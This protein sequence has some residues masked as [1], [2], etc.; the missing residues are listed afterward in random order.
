MTAE[1]EEKDTATY[2]PDLCYRCDG[3]MGLFSLKDTW[4][5]NVDGTLHNVP[6]FS[7]PCLKCLNCGVTLLN[8]WSDEI[9]L[10]CL[11]KYLDQRGLNTRWH[12]VRRAIRRRIQRYCDRWN[13]YMLRFDKWRGK[14]A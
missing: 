5:M 12:K 6:V 3:Q 13:W 4:K 10:Y 9:V 7:V 1:A 8:G 11:N 14:Y 2:K